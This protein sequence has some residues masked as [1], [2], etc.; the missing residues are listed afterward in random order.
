WMATDG[1]AELYFA[2]SPYNYALN[3]PVNAIDPDGNLVIFINGLGGGGKNYWKTW[4]STP[5]YKG[6]RS[7]GRDHHLIEIDNLVMNQ[8]ND[9]HATYIDGSPSSLTS[10]ISPFYRW[11]QGFK[12]AE[13]MAAQLIESLASDSQGN[14]TDS[15]KIITHSIE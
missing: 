6:R 2:N 14:I 9:H 4:T 7:V 11:S 12:D 10:N 8:L 3:T 13:N 1:K 5:I 15:M